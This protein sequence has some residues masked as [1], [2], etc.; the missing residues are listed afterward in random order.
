MRKFY[1]KA[2]DPDIFFPIVCLISWAVVA[3]MI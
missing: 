3:F 2:T 1:E